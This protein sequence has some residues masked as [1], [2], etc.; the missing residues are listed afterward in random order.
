MIEEVIN[1]PQPTRKQQLEPLYHRD[2]DILSGK[3]TNKDRVRN[4]K[5]WNAWGLKLVERLAWKGWKK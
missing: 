1:N 2:A 3:W 5:E 4:A